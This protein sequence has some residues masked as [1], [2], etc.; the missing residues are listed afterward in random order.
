MA[1]PIFIVGWRRAG[2]T[3]LTDLISRH[4]KVTGVNDEQM[5]GELGGSFESVFF[6]HLA[7]KYGDLKHPNNLIRFIEIFGSSSYFELTG[8]DKEFLY[9]ERPDTY[10]KVFRLTMDKFAEKNNAD[11]WVEKSPPHSYHIEELSRFYDDAKFIAIKRNV[12]EQVRSAIGLLELMGRVSVKGVSRKLK[13][14]QEL[15]AYYGA[16]KHIERFQKKHPSK[17]ILIA[18]EDLIKSR[19]ETMMAICDFLGLDF[20]PQMLESQYKPATSFKSEI[21]KSQKFLPQDVQMIHVL[22]PFFACLPYAFYRVLYMAKRTTH[23]Q[24]L[25]DFFYITKMKSLGKERF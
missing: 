1:I 7:G 10:E 23:G 6:S 18:F 22:S 5:P 15:L 8:L 16:N 21:E 14:L 2:T 17:I 3:L 24:Q 20:Q 11:F 9:S 4:S 19:R 13:I 12:V 25:P